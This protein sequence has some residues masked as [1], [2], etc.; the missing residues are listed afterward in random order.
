MLKDET[1]NA[2]LAG[3]TLPALK[4]L[5]EHALSAQIG[6]TS[7][8]DRTVHGLLSGCLTNIDDMRA[9]EGQVATTKIKNNMLAC[10]LV[11]TTLP[12]SVQISRP[13]VEQ[14]C[15]SIGQHLGD[16]GEVS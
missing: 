13:V 8:F 11:L 15:Y 7:T 4:Q 16:T 6:G 5:L 1:P 14:V 12:A 2:D 3:P 9:R 10:V